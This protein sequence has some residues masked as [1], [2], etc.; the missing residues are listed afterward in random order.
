MDNYNETLDYIHSLGMYSN[1]PQKDLSKIKYLCEL[2]DNPQDS[3]KI[4]HIAGTNGKGSTTAMLFNILTELGYK[5]GKFISP[6]IEK[7]NERIA[8]STENGDISDEDI[9]YYANK[10]RKTLEENNVPKE[11]MP[12]EFQFVMLMAFLYYKEKGCEF[13]VIETGLGGRLDSTNIIKSPIASV[14]T[15]IGLDHMKILGDTVEKI[16]HE[17]CGIIKE[18]SPVILY[19]LNEENV[20]NIVKS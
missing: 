8:A 20:I 11:L 15:Q 2:F 3:Y 1:P 9:I 13:A 4:I 6:Y 12:I 7:F 16:A 10:V 19:P 14:I 18:N 17:K 5:T